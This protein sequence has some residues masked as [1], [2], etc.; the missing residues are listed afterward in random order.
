MIEITEKQ[1]V[2][3]VSKGQISVQKES[4]TNKLNQIESNVFQHRAD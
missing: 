2:W 4:K 1:Q 3:A